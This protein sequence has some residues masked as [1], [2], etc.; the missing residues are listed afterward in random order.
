VTGERS[1][2]RSACNRSGS[3]AT[4]RGR[5]S[6][7][8][9]RS[10]ST[11]ACSRL[12]RGSCCRVRHRAGV[13]RL[14]G[15]CEAVLVPRRRARSDSLGV[16]VREQRGAGRRRLARRLPRAGCLTRTPSTSVLTGGRDSGTTPARRPTTP[17]A[18]GTRIDERNRFD[19]RPAL[20][21]HRV[22]PGVDVQRRPRDFLRSVAE[23][24]RRRLRRR[25][26]RRRGGGAV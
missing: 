6:R 16:G 1:S 17:A 23:E 19:E 13:S 15:R 24:G 14:Q 22:V 26:R 7:G 5:T 18:C 21:A 12:Q 20:H 10:T 3:R 2:R 9:R 25:L 4:H 8:H 11:S